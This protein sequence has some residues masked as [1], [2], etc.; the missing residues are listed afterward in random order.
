MVLIVIHG[1]SVLPGF[2]DGVC[3]PVSDSGGGAF[4]PQLLKQVGEDFSDVS[5]QK[6]LAGDDPTT[7][8]YGVGARS[9]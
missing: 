1:K 5:H 3:R 7:H 8:Y 4:I 6:I 2:V 9:A